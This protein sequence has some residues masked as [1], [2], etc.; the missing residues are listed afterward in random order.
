MEVK[1]DNLTLYVKGHYSSADPRPPLIFLHGFTLSAEEWAPLYSSYSNE[2]QPLGVDL[3]GHGNS[4]IPDAPKSYRMESCVVQLAQLC[5][6]LEIETA[7]WIGYSMGGRVLLSLAVRHPTFVRSMVLESTSPGIEDEAKRAERKR[8]DK[9]LAEF[10]QQN[11]IGKFVDRWMNN[12]IFDSQQ[13][14]DRARIQETRRIRLEQSRKGLALSLQN[15]GRGAMPPLWNHL[16]SLKMP[17]L[18]ITGELDEDHLFICQQM[19]RAL[20][21]SRSIVAGK[22]GHNVHLERP[23][24]FTEVT[25]DFLREIGHTSR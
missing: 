10:I 20:A 17:A 9:R 16:Q 12:P 22:T 15:M 14:V 6:N 24:Y 21:A 3:I 7:S 25:L 23:G 13:Q 5:R 8:E 18:L 2:F 4:S 1:T 11:P 19:H